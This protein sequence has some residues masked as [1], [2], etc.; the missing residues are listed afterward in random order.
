MKSKLLTI[1]IAMTYYSANF[2]NILVLLIICSGF[3]GT[4]IVS[5]MSGCILFLFLSRELKDP[6]FRFRPLGYR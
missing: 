6:R 5:E 4:V 3:E 1:V 2:Y